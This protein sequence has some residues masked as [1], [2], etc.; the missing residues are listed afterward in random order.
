MRKLN[1]ITAICFCCAIV[2]TSCHNTNDEHSGVIRNDEYNEVDIYF[3]LNKSQIPPDSYVSKWENYIIDKYNLR[4]NLTHIPFGY[5]K[6]NSEEN[7][8]SSIDGIDIN[9]LVDLSDTSGLIMLYRY[10]DLIELIS[11]D[12]I[13]PIN[14][15]LKSGNILNRLDLNGI[16]VLTDLNGNTWALPLR[17]TDAVRYMKRTYNEEWLKKA[18]M[19]V[20]ETID[21]FFEFARYV[22]NEDPDGNGVDDT[23][24]MDYSDEILYLYFEDI[25]KAFGCYSEGLSPFGFN[26]HKMEFENMILNENFIEAITFIK[27]LK[28]EQLIIN[29]D[30]VR[31][32]YK[33]ASSYKD[34]MNYDY[35][36]EKVYGYFIK[37]LNETLLIQEDYYENCLAVLKYTDT[38]GEKLEQ[39][40]NLIYSSPDSFMDLNYGIEGEGYYDE[41]SYY[42]APFHPLSN[43]DA[44]HIGLYVTTN[45]PDLADKPITYSEDN[46]ISRNQLKV[47]K[48]AHKDRQEANQKAEK[49]S[50]TNLVYRISF[51]VY[52]Y[53]Y[54]E[55]SSNTKISALTTLFS[56]ILNHGADIEDAVSQYSK[57]VN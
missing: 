23:Y 46:K 55:V 19:E 24:I 18:E 15:Y 44:P 6:Q 57:L 48:Q 20:P 41:D 1:L 30:L 13:M 27:L 10:E 21:E 37:G 14:Q 11:R 3:P 22:A 56:E 51:D 8:E 42:R 7:S 52:S 12:L 50:G 53:E 25:F 9:M 34:S 38:P 5:I 39:F 54:L 31:K 43:N 26:P 28:D 40:Y 35:V 33:V 36:K 47:I 32:E 4:I 29:K 17:G 2:L 49:Y 16:E 45:R